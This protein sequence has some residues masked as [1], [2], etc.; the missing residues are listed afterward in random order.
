[1]ATYNGPVT[2]TLPDG[3]EVH[4]DASL[5]SRQSGTRTDWSGQLIVTTPDTLFGG[6]GPN[7]HSQLRTPTGSSDMIISE[8]RPTNNGEVARILG[9]GPVPF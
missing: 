1:M 5:S 6:A 3:S 9:S 4:A 8:V 2:I 7:Q